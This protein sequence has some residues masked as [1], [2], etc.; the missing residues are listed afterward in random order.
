MKKI[1]VFLLFAVLIPVISNL[2]PTVLKP[3]KKVHG[4]W[5]STAVVVWTALS[6]MAS[7]LA[8]LFF[9]EMKHSFR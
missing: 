8:N 5:P 6:G 3:L 2:L 4:K 7:A 9:Q 1:L